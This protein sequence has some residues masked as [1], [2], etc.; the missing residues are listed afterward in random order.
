MRCPDCSKFVPFNTEEDPQ[1]DNEEFDGE[2][3]TAEVTRI[4]TCENCGTELKGYTFDVEVDAKVEEPEESEA[5]KEEDLDNEPVDED[6]EEHEHEWEV[7]A[8]ATPTMRSI[9]KDR[10]GRPI[11]KSRYIRTEYGIEVEFDAK[12]DCGATAHANFEDYVAAS[13][14]DELV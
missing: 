4:L 11:T 2:S 6:E 3:F 10:H 9:T 13:G 12:C 14:M 7:T 5:V 8:E 1:V